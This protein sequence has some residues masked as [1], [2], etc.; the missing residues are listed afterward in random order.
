MP[1]VVYCPSALP[2]EAWCRLVHRLDDSNLENEINHDIP[3]DA[4]ASQHSAGNDSLFVGDGNCKVA[5]Y[6]KINI[7]D[8]VLRFSA[9][10]LRIVSLASQSLKKV[11][12]PLAGS[13]SLTLQR[14]DTPLACFIML[15]ADAL[16]DQA[17][18]ARD[19]SVLTTW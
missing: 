19:F 6:G 3:S 5:D 4:L 15:S 11:L 9:G 7:A 14:Q 2:I 10:A 17:G 13:G 16:T 12:Q 8:E 18:P 1:M